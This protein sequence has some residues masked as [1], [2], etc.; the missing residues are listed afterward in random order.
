MTNVDFVHIFLLGITAKD[1]KVDSEKRS[2]PANCVNHSTEKPIRLVK[3]FQRNKMKKCNTYKSSFTQLKE[4]P[5]TYYMIV[6][7]DGIN[8][9]IQQEISELQ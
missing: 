4:P 9:K 8:F 1:L 5:L 7:K 6:V 3:I 2:F